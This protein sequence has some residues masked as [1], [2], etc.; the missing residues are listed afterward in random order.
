MTHFNRFGAQG[1]ARRTIENLREAREELTYS[2]NTPTKRS[3][4]EVRRV[5]DIIDAAI[6]AAEAAQRRFGEPGK[7]VLEDYL[8]TDA[9]KD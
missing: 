6:E 1:T 7:S 8:P 9:A 4:P 3:I 5:L 2:F